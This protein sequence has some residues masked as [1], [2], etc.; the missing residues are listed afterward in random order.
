[1]FLMFHVSCLI[2]KTFASYRL[3]YS[4]MQPI[5]SYLSKRSTDKTFNVD[6]SNVHIS[7][8]SVGTIVAQYVHATEEPVPHIG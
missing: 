6:Q 5:G 1:M 7:I 2:M 3:R 4:A 8:T